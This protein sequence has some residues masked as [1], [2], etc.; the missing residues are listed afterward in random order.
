MADEPPLHPP[1]AVATTLLPAVPPMEPDGGNP[2]TIISACSRRCK[3][4]TACTHTSS[5]NATFVDIM[6]LQHCSSVDDC[7]NSVDASSI[8]QA[9]G[10]RFWDLRC[11]GILPQISIDGAISIWTAD[12]SG[13][14]KRGVALSLKTTCTVF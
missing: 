8:H 2:S 11:C 7:S 1:A 9:W 13:L 6:A 5:S 14:R 10:R 12:S 3:S 4:C